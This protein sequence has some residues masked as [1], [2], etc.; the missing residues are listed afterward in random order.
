MVKIIFKYLDTSAT[1]AST[2]NIRFVTTMTVA[3]KILQNVSDDGTR[4]PLTVLQCC[5]HVV[6]LSKGLHAPAQDFDSLD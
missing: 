4:K 1:Q 3:Q 2:D 6:R 5:S